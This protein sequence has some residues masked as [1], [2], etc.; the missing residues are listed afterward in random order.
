MSCRILPSP[1][2]SAARPRRVP[3]SGPYRGLGSYS[4]AERDVFFGRETEVAEVLE[5]LR[6]QSA[7][8]LVGPGGSGKSSLAHAG[9]IPLIEEGALGGGVACFVDLVPN[10]DVDAVLGGEAFEHLFLVLFVLS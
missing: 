7:V 9:V 3:G 4:A 1:W 8:V 10:W 2:R 5:R 6:T